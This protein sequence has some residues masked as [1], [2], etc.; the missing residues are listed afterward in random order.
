MTDKILL[1]EFYKGSKVD[2]VLICN[3]PKPT[4]TKGMGSLGYKSV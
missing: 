4:G 2:Y 3:L 1:F